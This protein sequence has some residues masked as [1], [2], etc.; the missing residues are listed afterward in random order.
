MKLLTIYLVTHSVRRYYSTISTEVHLLNIYNPPWMSEHLTP[1]KVALDNIQSSAA[2]EQ[3]D[4]S[5]IQSIIVENLLLA[6]KIDFVSVT[7]IVSLL[8][9]K[10]Y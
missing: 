2:I 8:L 10:Q 5:T 1:H 3:N 4:C 7:N 9:E 6:E